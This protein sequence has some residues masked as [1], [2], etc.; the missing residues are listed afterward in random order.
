[1][2]SLGAQAIEGT[3]GASDPFWSPDGR[4]IGFFADHKLKRVPAS[5]GTV[6]TFCDAPEPRGGTWGEGD[7]IVF[8]PVPF[9]GL[10]RVS[11]GGGTPVALTSPREKEMTHRLPAFLPGG[12]RVLFFQATALKSKENGIYCVDLASG[13]MTRVSPENSGPLIAPG[14]L[15]FV[16]GGDLMAQ[17]FD[18]GSLR[19][20][21]EAAIVAQHVWFN[22]YRWTA[23]ASV[24]DTGLL[25][26]E[27]GGEAT[28]SQ[29]TWLDLDGRVAG[30]VGAPAPFDSIAISP[31]GRRALAVIPD[32]SGTNHFWMY[33]LVRSVASRFAPDVTA[34]SAAWSPDGKQVAYSDMDGK[35]YV[36]AMNGLSEAR[37]L[38]KVVSVNERPTSWSVDGE[39]L[40][41]DRQEPEGWNLMTVPLTGDPT[42]RPLVAT[43]AQETLGRVSPDGK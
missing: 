9:G 6:Q 40:V 31:D 5:G 1:M 7:V 41:I 22:G 42:P 26:A 43:P 19:L 14:F 2:D 34:G 24:S 13:R 37:L 12:R 33:D 21:G 29:L 8:A 38:I 10:Q 17:R 35:I 20:E 30:T 4:S 32:E 18:A 27:P 3:D 36:K 25:V 23:N 28:K 39:T 15:L 16:R 11:A